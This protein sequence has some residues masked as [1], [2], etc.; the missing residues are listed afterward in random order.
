[1]TVAARRTFPGL[2]AIRFAA[3]VLV[4]LYHLCVATWGSPESVTFS[5]VG[6]RARFPELL[7]YTWFGFVGVE[8][9]FVLSGLVIACSAAHASARAFAWSRFMRLYPTVWICAT[10]TAIV[11]LLTGAENA[12]SVVSGWKH[13]VA[14]YPVG[15][16]VDSVY[17]TLGIEMVFYACVFGLLCVG[18][19]RLIEPFALG[20][21]GVS[22]VYWVG[23]D[24]VDPQ[25][26]RDHLWDRSLELSLAPYGVFF[27]LGVGVQSVMNQGF[28]PRRLGSIIVML[29][30]SFIEIKYKADFN[31]ARLGTA[32]PIVLPEC[33]FAISV[34][35]MFASM[36]RPGGGS[37]ARVL[38]SIG[39][40]TYPLYLLHDHV[41]AVVIRIGGGLGLNRYLALS[42]A[43][44]L[45]LVAAAWIAAAGE[46]LL[47][48]ALQALGGRLLALFAA[49]GARARASMKTSSL[50]S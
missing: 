13:S 40:M 3:A 14:L 12:P 24:L 23:G 5:I 35:A 38:R 2:D 28:S 42:T 9:F 50:Q 39:L 15:P 10:M 31:S 47:R 11:L 34:I 20:L 46:P 6:G 49:I 19:R 37:G 26:L 17:W 8:I 27:A 16:W 30:A 44:V 32:L 18:S 4:M 43:I 7:D 41:G 36:R 45:C 1:M 48:Q 25:F 33:A 29:W 22:A 21:G